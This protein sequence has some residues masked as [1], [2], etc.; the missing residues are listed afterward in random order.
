[1]Q[2]RLNWMTLN[3]VFYRYGTI[4]VIMLMFIF[5]PCTAAI[6]IMPLGDSITEGIAGSTYDIG[7]RRTLY[8]SLTAA[9]YD[10]DFVG[11][12]ANGNLTD[13]DRDHEGHGGW[14]ANEIRDNIIGWLTSTPA[15]IVLLK[16][17]TND[18]W[19]ND[20][21]SGANQPPSEI[22]VE[23]SQI[24]DNIHTFELANE[25]SITVVLA[26]IINRGSDASDLVLEYTSELND[27][28]EDLYNTRNGDGNTPKLALVDMY[29][30]L[31][32]PGDLADTAHPNDRGYEK[33]GYVWFNA[34]DPL[35]ESS[36]YNVALAASSPLHSTNDNLTC[37]YTLASSDSVAATAW[38]KN[39]TPVMSLYLPMEAGSANAIKDYSGNSVTCTVGGNTTWS[40][41]AGH[42]GNGAFTFD[43]DG[44]YIDAGQTFPI[45]SSYTKTAWIYRTGT[46]ENIISGGTSSGGHV[47]WLSDNVLSA[48][49]NNSWFAV[50]DSSA[51]SANT[52]YFV[53]V[54]Y[55][56]ATGE[57]T[58]YK[59][60]VAVDNATVTDSVTDQ[61]T[62]IGAFKC[63]HEWL[64]TI[65]DVR[66]YNSVLSPNQIAAM[67]NNGIGNSNIIVS[68]QTLDSQSW[69]AEVTPFLSSQKGDTVRSNTVVIGG[70]AD[71]ANVI[72]TAETSSNLTT[73]NLT[74][75]YDLLGTNLTSATAWYKNSASAM[76]LYLPME[77]GTSN[78]STDYSGNDVPCILAGNPAWS[79]TAGHDGKGAYI[80]DG[81]GD[82]ID[83]GNIFP[84]G[85]SYTK[86]AWVYRTSDSGNNNIIS[87]ELSVGGHAFWAPDTAG[88]RLSAGQNG[89]WYT[90]QDTTKMATNTWYFVAV[91]YSASSRVMTLYKNGVQVDS[92]TSVANDV[93]DTRALVG[94]HHF[95]SLWIGTIDDAK[96]YNYALSPAQITAM[97]NN[98]L[99]DNNT[100]V[101][102]ETANNQ[103]WQSAVTP[104]SKTESGIT[105]YSNIIAIGSA[106]PEVDNTEIV[107]TSSHNLTTDSLSCTYDLLPPSVTS[108]TA[109][110]QD[111]NPIMQLYLPMEGGAA[112]AVTDYSGN[113]VV[114][115]VV[116]DV[117]W[118]AT[119]GH[120]GRGALI[121]D[122]TEDCIDAG[123]IFPTTSSYTKSA[124]VYRT[125]NSGNNNIISGD[126]IA[127]GHAFWAPDTTS[128][129]LCAGHNNSWNIVQDSTRMLTNTW[130]FV[131]VTYDASAGTM[132]LYKNGIQVDSA[133]SVASNVTDATALIGSHHY[134][135]LWIGTID[136]A[137]IYNRALSPEQITAMYNNGLG[138]NN[139]IVS[140]E[141][142][143]YQAWHA[144]VTP[145]SNV[146]PGLTVSTNQITILPHIDA[147]LDYNGQV[148]L[149]DL[150]IL[151]DNW[152]T[153]GDISAGD[154][155]GNTFIDILDMAEIAKYW[156]EQ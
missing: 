142:A 144:E 58:L 119:A 35:M 91:T 74:C 24:L 49:H 59:N 48:G 78:A 64:G 4:C 10:V 110:Y 33:M 46:A 147:D 32:Y 65:D 66:I 27:L 88:N 40:S 130:Y 17:G 6:C 72:L 9:G 122:G 123:E 95:G 98:G 115:T 127:G 138:D 56:A 155:D 18:I 96:I 124:W 36:V 143:D 105:R 94:S 116:G 60:G 73:E 23:I 11:S 1:M 61:T 70:A 120:D 101:S 8:L 141:T 2:S 154:L 106:M 133:S 44:D 117:T 30:A 156:L 97:Y 137:R 85:S 81:N 136:D 7:Y 125:S 14:C 149:S 148:G 150:N 71:V 57:M 111:T 19:H 41:T 151:C 109:W 28:I 47:F 108:V 77:G 13:F 131:A 50:Q 89:S 103:T 16:I 118:S 42:D 3:K 55:N 52:W 153:S 45:N 22:I 62:L 15:D 135:S 20:H 121:F 152:L 80:F 26:K 63:D 86:S 53:S 129:K 113:S 39:D 51:I 92:A 126:A 114:C 5:S 25:T 31:T 67:Y 146:Q 82:Y 79:P 84:A 21:V 139:T 134:G 99:G 68:Q 83:A 34:L 107:S 100:I 90:V 12:C 104:F 112:N 140:Q 69:Q 76:E 145:F 75:T 132:V 54:T 38:Y 43:G 29:N 93:T 37:T 128:N 102:Q 87:G